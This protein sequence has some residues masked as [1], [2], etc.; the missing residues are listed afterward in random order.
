MRSYLIAM[1]I[2][3]VSFPL[4]VW[5][6]MAGQLVLGWILLL[7]AVLIPSV[8]VGVANAVDHR[9]ESTRQTPASPVH[10]L[11]HGTTEPTPETAKPT[12]RPTE[13]IVGTVISSRV[14]PYRAGAAAEEPR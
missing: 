1:G 5:A 12:T 6:F 11:G 3:T 8:A 10:G 9:G 13:N 14:T 4:A 7:A 2:R